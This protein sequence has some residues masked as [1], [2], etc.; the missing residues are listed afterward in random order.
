[1]FTR[2]ELSRG[3]V[4]RIDYASLSRILKLTHRHAQTPLTDRTKFC[5]RDYVVDAYT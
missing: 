4:V 1:M 3:S 5:T 2:T